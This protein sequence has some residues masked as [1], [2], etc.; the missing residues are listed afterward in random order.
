MSRGELDSSRPLSTDSD[1]LLP[2]YPDI[3]EEEGGGEEEEE[4][5]SNLM[6]RPGFSEESPLRGDQA[7]AILYHKAKYESSA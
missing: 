2:P 5:D 7:R 4:E 6:I 1:F 3:H